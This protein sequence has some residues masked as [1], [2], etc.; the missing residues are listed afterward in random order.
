[1]PRLS[2]FADRDG[3][4]TFHKTGLRAREQWVV[5][6][7]CPFLFFMENQNPSIPASKKKDYRSLF[8]LIS[9]VGLVILAWFLN[10][11]IGLVATIVAY[12]WVS[13]KQ[14]LLAVSGWALII[15]LVIGFN[16][17]MWN[18]HPVLGIIS[19]FITL[20]AKVF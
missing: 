10:P 18:I 15:I 3:Q 2:V 8:I 19:L 14:T 7:G 16:I 9:V 17:L 6:Y 5:R 20:G 1:L 12:A 13:K 4:S 11:I